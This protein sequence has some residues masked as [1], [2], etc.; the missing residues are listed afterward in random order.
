M[1]VNSWMEALLQDSRYAVRVFIKNPIFT[2]VAT[3]T[4]ALGTGVNTAIFTLFNLAFRPLPIKD[5]HSI[6]RLDWGRWA[7]DRWFT[8]PDYA[9]LRDHTKIMSGVIASSGGRPTL[10]LGGQSTSEEPQRISSELVSENFFSVL[11]ASTVLGRTF[12]AEENV[13]GKYPYAV[14]SYPFWQRRFGGNP[15]VVG[16]TLQLNG[17]NFTVIGVTARD[18]FGFGVRPPDLWLPLFMRGQIPPQDSRGDWFESRNIRWLM[19]SGRL[20][21]DRTVAEANAEMGV[22]SSQLAPY[23]QESEKQPGNN[24]QEIDQIR[25]VRAT[26]ALRFGFI[27]LELIGSVTLATMMVLLISIANIVN[28]LLARAAGRQKEIGMRLCL[29]A[30]RRR[31]VRQLLTESILLAVLG[32][33]AGLV[34]AWWSIKAFLIS[35]LPFQLLP[36]DPEWLNKNLTLDF[37]VLG[38]TF[39][40]SLITGVAFGLI[41]ALRSTRLD[42]ATAVKDETTSFGRGMTRSRLRQGLVVAQLAFC[43]VLL[44]ISGLVLR[45]LGRAADIDPGFDPGKILAVEPQ[46]AFA[47]G[48]DEVQTQRFY[49]ELT[50]RLKNQPGVLSVTQVLNAPL[51][52]M[53]RKTISIKSDTVGERVARAYYNACAANYFETIGIPIVRGRSFNEEEV[54][55]RSN[56]VI[57]TES[58]AQRLWPRQAPIGQLLRPDPNAPFAEVIGVVKNT[59]TK[60]DGSD[61]LQFYQPLSNLA[62][63][64]ILLRTSTDARELDS[65]IRSLVKSMAPSLLVDTYTVEEVIGSS[66]DIKAAHSLLALSACLGL[67][68]MLLASMGLYGVIA[69]SVTQRRHEI[70]V[71]MALGARRRDVLWLVVS[72]GLRMIGIGVALGVTGGAAFSRVLSSAL[73]GLNPFDPT[74]YAGVSLFLALVAL[75]ATYLPARRASRVDPVEA[76]RY[77]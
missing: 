12:T 1:Q 27:P 11:G 56:V 15:N 64:A 9:Y 44:I 34:L 74:T 23:I 39:M 49:Q 16:Q 30:T 71:R 77:E 6:V 63:A 65:K 22:L 59:Q 73:F 31:V 45:G 76:L 37:R 26:P 75:L 55:S 35:T 20:K 51:T 62:G 36:S 47:P 33:C 57:V 48:Y 46:L 17:T 29:G 7:E 19:I 25:R 43:L 69:Y 53:S 54:R 40:L 61:P 72:Q 38:Y 24:N 28:L 60:I 4:I 52:S 2:I 13:I 70:G 50:E 67:L 8:Y 58:T 18:F 42:L 3:L 21:P 10:V 41:P 68:A 14:I 66:S 5:A 32:G